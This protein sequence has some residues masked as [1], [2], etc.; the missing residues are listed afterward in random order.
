MSLYARLDSPFWWMVLEGTG[1]KE[2]THIRRDANSPPLR[3]Q[4]RTEAEE[5][6]HARMVQ[7]ARR[8]VGLSVPSRATFDAF[9]QWYDTHHT[10]KHRGV[11]RER[12]ILALLRKHFGPRR[13]DEIRPVQWKE[14]ETTRMQSCVALSTVGR[15]LAVMKALLNAAVGEHLVVNPLANVRRKTV[16]LP[17]KRTM[18][19]KEEP[20]FLKALEDTE[21]R[22]IY[23]VGL[24]TLL[25]QDNL[26][27]LRRSQHQGSR[28]VVQTKTGPHQVPLTGPSSLQR[29]AATVLKRRMPTNNRGYFFPTWQARF[30]AAPTP[31]LAR[32]QFLRIV[33]RAAEAAGLPWG[34]QDQ[35]VVW[36]T[37]TRASGAT[38]L[39]REHQVDI[40]SVQLLG[41]WR[42]L[43]Q[44]AAYLG[45]DRGLNIAPQGRKPA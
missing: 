33:R 20:A 41:G 13:L 31:G 28:L 9:S 23:I 43:D 22:D 18:T 15:E 1:R 8:R 35:G 5:I 37:L 11:Q 32:M 25:R 14:Y 44:M 34:L 38:R 10:A 17:P 30:A 45:L 40:R 12:Q 39:L 27:Q 19:A 16:P 42:S 29:R 7:V 3:K 24:G 4:L 36:H 2:S 6:Y 21:I 26:L